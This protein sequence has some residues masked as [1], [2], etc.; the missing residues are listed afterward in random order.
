MKKIGC[1][2]IRHTL[3]DLLIQVGYCGE[4][5]IITRHFKEVAVMISWDD[6]KMIEQMFRERDEKRT[7]KE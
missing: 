4:R 1:E 6:W 3:G 5:V 2:V 7:L